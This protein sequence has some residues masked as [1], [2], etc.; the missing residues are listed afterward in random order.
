MNMISAITRKDDYSEKCHFM[1]RIYTCGH[2]LYARPR[3]THVG[4][5]GHSSSG[6]KPCTNMATKIREV[7][8]ESIC[9]QCLLRNGKRRHDPF[10]IF[11]KRAKTGI[12][13]PEQVAKWARFTAGAS[14]NIE[15]EIDEESVVDATAVMKQGIKNSN[16]HGQNKLAE[17]EDLATQILDL[18]IESHTQGGR[19]STEV[20]QATM[21]PE[22]STSTYGQQP[23]ESCLDTNKPV[24]NGIISKAFASP[25]EQGKQAWGNCANGEDKFL[26]TAKLSSPCWTDNFSDH[27]EDESD[28]G[29]SVLKVDAEQDCVTSMIESNEWVH[30]V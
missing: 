26:L 14:Q 24:I 4:I 23:K 7:R 25:G 22:E 2:K 11:L 12:A 15:I 8:M 17:P 16:A 27:E 19:H 21:P 30:V 5:C 13:T 20:N 29:W 6:A 18:N 10:E 1:I 3:I 28:D 9:A